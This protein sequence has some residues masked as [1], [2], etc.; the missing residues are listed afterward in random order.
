VDKLIVAKFFDHF[1]YALFSIFLS[2][3]TLGAVASP[4]NNVQWQVRRSK[5]INSQLVVNTF[6]VRYSVN[7]SDTTRLYTGDL[8]RPQL[9][10]SVE[11]ALPDTLG[12]S[13]SKL[14]PKYNCH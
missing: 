13:E 4:S 11:T 2:Q 8:G 6:R 1:V 10:R 5:L 14:R 12:R 3:N 7:G 9:F